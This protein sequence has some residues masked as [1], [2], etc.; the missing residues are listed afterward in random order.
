MIVFCLSSNSSGNLSYLRGGGGGGQ[1]E[2][3]RRGKTN[4][5]FGPKMLDW[6]VLQPLTP[7]L[8]WILCVAFAI[9][10]LLA[11]SVGANDVSNSFGTSVGS[12]VLTVTQACILAT[13]FEMAGATLLGYSVC[14]TFRK[15]MYDVSQYEGSQREL[16]LG[17]L[18]C[19][20]GSAS[21]NIVAT[22]LK[23]P[24]SGTHS[25]VGATIGFSVVLR[26][27]DSIRWMD[28]L[29]IVC[30][31]FASP[32][33]SGLISSIIYT[34]IS[35]TII[36]KIDPLRHGL[37][38]LPLFYGITIFINVASVVIDGPEVMGLNK[39]PWY[40]GLFIALVCATVAISCVALIQVPRLRREITDE[41]MAQRK[42][43]SSVA[44][45]R[46]PQ[47]PFNYDNPAFKPDNDGAPAK[48]QRAPDKPKRG[49]QTA[50]K[51]TD[52]RGSEAGALGAAS[53]KDSQQ[54]QPPPQD[55]AGGAATVASAKQRPAVAPKPAH[56]RRQVAQD[57]VGE[58]GAKQ[59]Q[60]FDEIDLS[61]ESGGGG[62]GVKQRDKQAIDA[63]RDLEQGRAAQQSAADSPGSFEPNAPGSQVALISA[64]GERYEI[65]RL[66][67][68]LQILT[69][70]FASFAHGTNDVSN[71]VAP[72]IPIWNIYASGEE[73]T[74][75]PTQVWIL[76]FGSIGI[77]TGLWAWGRAVMSTISDGLTK[78][79]PS[80]GFSV[81]LGA[82][83]SVLVATK[84]GLP[85]S[86]THC[87]VGSLVV[88]GFVSQR[89]LSQDKL[90]DA[91]AC[92]EQQKT[93]ASGSQQLQITDDREQRGNR[94]QQQQQE[95]AG[96]EDGV[97]WKMF[98]NIAITWVSTVPLAGLASALVMYTL[99]M[100]L[101]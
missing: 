26:G 58:S 50:H 61:P 96:D 38:A 34:V 51:T 68:S 16:M 62:G 57:S 11:F 72:L 35:K 12:R 39:L 64:C 53:G 37:K 13:I 5:N 24:I 14:D 77:C 4:K 6:E 31:W 40:G 94:Q 18:S 88:V 83:I 42:S 10:F 63:A 55:T 45:V 91:A 48:R 56:L 32:I 82:A 87:K 101:L 73:N 99:K 75:V 43:R 21:W 46:R 84:L 7:D 8:F 22:F 49:A 30:S 95:Q 100:L 66:F 54:Q 27:W 29:R 15:K 47:T 80:K 41:L 74:A 69:A 90:L 3:V 23:M 19:L 59:A 98:G 79:T 92:A 78:I 67:A 60:Q 1:V 44:P 25:I 86:T 9:A 28:M 85:I 20:I 36:C 89:F 2:S 65:A 17:A 70:C 52:E 97:D 71:A 81:E 33:L 76:A 93:S